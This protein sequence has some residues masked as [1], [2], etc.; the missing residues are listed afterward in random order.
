MI[1]LDISVVIITHNNY[2]LKE[3]CIETVVFS[4]IN[5]KE[6]NFEIIIVDNYSDKD[7]WE[8]LESLMIT[9]LFH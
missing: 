7:D 8:K 6:V 9:Y 2:S 5:Q 3:G 4:L 1:N